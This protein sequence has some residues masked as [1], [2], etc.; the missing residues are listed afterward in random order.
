MKCVSCGKD[1]TIGYTVLPSNKILC[2]D[3]SIDFE[4]ILHESCTEG[5]EKCYEKH[6]EWIDRAGLQRELKLLTLR[7]TTFRRQYGRLE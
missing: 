1:V 3:C 6:R 4:L 5:Y 7:I 2:N